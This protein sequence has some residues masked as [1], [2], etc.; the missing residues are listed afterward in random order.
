MQVARA[1][2]DAD[3][4]ALAGQFRPKPGGDGP[5]AGA[6]APGRGRRD[7]RLAAGERTAQPHPLVV[8]TA[9]IGQADLPRLAS[10]ETV[11][12]LA[13]RSTSEE[14]Q[15]GIVDLLSRIGTN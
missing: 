12:F 4:V 15:E 8:Y 6:P 10:G 2:S 1:A 13:E 3:A 9:A 7:R 11:L 5:D 14:V